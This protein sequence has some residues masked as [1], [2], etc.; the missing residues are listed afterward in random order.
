[1]K[2]YVQVEAETTTQVSLLVT[3]GQIA[4][5]GKPSIPYKQ[6]LCHSNVILAARM[7]YVPFAYISTSCQ[8][9]VWIM[10]KSAEQI[11][12]VRFDEPHR[13]VTLVL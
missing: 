9:C 5:R 12:M 13:S 4:S 6:R 11:F 3:L 2:V 8:E 7:S 1:M 10:N